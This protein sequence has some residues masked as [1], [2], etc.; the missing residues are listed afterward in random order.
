M[1]TAMTHAEL[2]ALVQ[3]VLDGTAT[4]EQRARLEAHLASTPA[5][6]ARRRELEHVFTLLR[7]VPM[8]EAPS[9]LRQSVL[10]RLGPARE[11]GVGI[12][13]PRGAFALRGTLRLALPF[14]LGFAAGA[15]AFVGWTGGPGRELGGEAVGTMMP[16]GGNG[17]ETLRAGSMQVSVRGQRS[18]DR[19][20]LRIGVES[21]R[22]P[23]EIEIGFD[24]ASTRLA[25]LRQADARAGE[26]EAAPGRV[27]LLPERDGTYV[28][29]LVH[30]DPGARVELVL[31]SGGDTTRRTMSP[32]LGEDR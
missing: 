4:A 13:R 23:D 11:A 15:I 31:R 3:E 7:G 26:I 1:R 20:V 25:S 24:P 10:R 2:D 16:A 5:D 14:A 9:G 19:Q 30:Q 8:A 32:D 28:V 18:G 17:G 21:A 27:R 12:G 22:R 29:E 6:A